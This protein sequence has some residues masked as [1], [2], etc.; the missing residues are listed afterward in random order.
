VTAIRS[1]SGR[2]V[3]RAWQH[4]RAQR[5]QLPVRKIDAASCERGAAV[6]NANNARR[7][8]LLAS[9]G[10]IEP[11]TPTDVLNRRKTYYRF[12][13]ID[14]AKKFMRL[15]RQIAGYLHAI[16]EMGVPARVIR[17]HVRY[18]KRVLPSSLS[19]VADLLH[20]LVWQ[21]G[22]FAKARAVCDRV[23]G[24]GHWVRYDLPDYDRCSMYPGGTI[25]IDPMETLRPLSAP[26]VP[27]VVNPA[28]QSEMEVFL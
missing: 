27:S 15:R 6:T 25:P 3:A 22:G 9:A 16:R 12:S 5:C 19:Y 24:R 10:L 4:V 8:P 1:K 23:C 2:V 13:E 11:V 21:A 14:D 18:W 26:S 7:A 20:T 28:V 17:D